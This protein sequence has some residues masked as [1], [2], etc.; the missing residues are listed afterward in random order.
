MSSYI[1]RYIRVIGIFIIIF[2]LIFICVHFLSKGYT[3]KYSI[4]DFSIKE[5]YTKDEQNEHDNY[6]QYR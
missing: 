1:K 3:N 4:D 6:T 5:V 2:I